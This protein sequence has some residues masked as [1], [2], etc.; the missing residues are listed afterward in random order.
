[1][2]NASK[3]LIIAGSILIALIVISLGVLIFNKFGGTARQMANM[4][5]EEILIFNAELTPYRGEHISGSQVKS[6]IQLVRSIDQNAKTTNDFERRVSIYDDPSGS[7]STSKPFVKF[8]TNDTDITGT[9]TVQLNKYFTV[10]MNY[11]SIGLIDKIFVTE[12]K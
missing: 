9:G 5:K 4:D 12:N 11:N 10:K 2:E 3:A 7:G 8:E 6:L 1:M